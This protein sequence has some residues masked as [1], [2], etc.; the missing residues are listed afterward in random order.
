MPAPTAHQ[1]GGLLVSCW[2]RAHYQQ[3]PPVSTG[4]KAVGELVGRPDLTQCEPPAAPGGGCGRSHHRPLDK[5]WALVRG[6][7]VLVRAEEIRRI[8]LALEREQ[9]SVLMI[10]IGDSHMR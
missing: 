5:A 8:E 2:R 9:P 7:D 3:L 6:R 1:Q 10:P 4:Q